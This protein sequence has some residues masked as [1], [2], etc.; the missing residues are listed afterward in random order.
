VESSVVSVSA[1]E[2]VLFGVG[3]VGKV[4]GED[5]LNGENGWIIGLGTDPGI[6]VGL[7]I[8]QAGRYWFKT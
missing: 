3:L 6:L 4:D 2:G 8:S 1:I 5:G 7:L